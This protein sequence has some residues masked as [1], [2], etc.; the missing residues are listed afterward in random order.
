M[1]NC[2]YACCVVLCGCSN[3]RGIICIIMVIS[4]LTTLSKLRFLI[5]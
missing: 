3:L 4:V 2:P 5:L 1:K